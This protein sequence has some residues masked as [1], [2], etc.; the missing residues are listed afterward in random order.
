MT[1]AL[2]SS[3]TL[4]LECAYYYENKGDQSSVE[5][6]I[7]LYQKGGDPSRA[8]ELCF[9]IEYTNTNNKNNKGNKTTATTTSNTTNNNSTNTTAVFELINSI[10]KDINNKTSPYIIDKCTAFLIQHQ[11]YEKAIELYLIINK[12]IQAINICIQYKVTITDALLEKL[13]PPSG[14]GSGDGVVGE[15]GGEAVEKK[16]ILLLLAKTLKDQVRMSV[17]VYMS[18]FVMHKMC[19]HICV[20]VYVYVCVVNCAVVQHWYECVYI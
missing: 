4:M 18:E 9:S 7:Q 8:L 20:T 5:K 13:I 17:Y 11:Q 1:Y 6:A 16:E 14:S 3:P 19:T 12:Y 2:K 15:A 10:A